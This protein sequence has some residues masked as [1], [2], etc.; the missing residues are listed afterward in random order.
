MRGAL[1]SLVAAFF[2]SRLNSLMLK[3]ARRLRV[4]Y[5][6]SVPT[7]VTGPAPSTTTAR[8]QYG[9]RS[10]QKSISPVKPKPGG[11]TVASPQLRQMRVNERHRRGAFADR[12]ANALYRSRPHVTDCIRTGNA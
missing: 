2:A 10:T 3:A 5:D 8:P 6:G 9:E 12:T 1:S 11:A 4:P 7:L